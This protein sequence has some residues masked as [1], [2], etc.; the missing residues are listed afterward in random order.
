MIE[1]ISILCSLL[2]CILTPIEMRKIQSGWTNKKFE[3]N[4]EGFLVAYRKQMTM[5]IYL[6]LGL[7]GLTAVLILIEDNPGE[8][9]VKAVAAAI[10]LAVAAICFVS[11]RNL[12]A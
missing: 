9:I 5:M 2:I 7:G 4:R 11:R 8:R 1:L 10:W 3:G 12:P 6:G